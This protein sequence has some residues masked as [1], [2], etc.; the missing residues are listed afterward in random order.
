MDADKLLRIAEALKDAAQRPDLDSGELARLAVSLRMLADELEDRD[1]FAVLYL[2]ERLEHL[3]LVA[4][5][6]ETL[7]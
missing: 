1:T 4:F 7:N 5:D 3:A 6:S 2:V